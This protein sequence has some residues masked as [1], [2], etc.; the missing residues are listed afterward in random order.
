M[1]RLIEKIK[2]EATIKLLTGLHIGGNT[3]N[4]EIGGIDNPVIKLANKGGQPYIPGSSLK[5]KMRSLLEQSRG[6]SKPGE[7]EKIPVKLPVRELFGYAN[8][9]DSGEKNSKPSRLIVRD[10]FLTEDSEIELRN[11]PNLDMPYVEKKSENTIDRITA[12]ANPRSMERVP[13]GAVFN[14]EFIINKWRDDGKPEVNDNKEIELLKEGI[15]LLENDYLGGS[16][17]R[18]YGQLKIDI[19]KETVLSAENNWK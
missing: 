14:V 3:D 6:I 2:I 18:G 9:S 10:A 7:L 16:G 13:A 12:R 1:E 8:G 4:V 19:V 11:N 15:R 5:G 17:S